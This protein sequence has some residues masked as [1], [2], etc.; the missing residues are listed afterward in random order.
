[1][2]PTIT[3]LIKSDANIILR[4]DGIVRIRELS[5]REIIFTSD[6]VLGVW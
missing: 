5:A 3:A 2:T 1:L 6:S 4:Y